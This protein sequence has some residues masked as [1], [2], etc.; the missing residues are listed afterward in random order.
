MPTENALRSETRLAA[1]LAHSPVVLYTLPLSRG[2]SQLTWVSGSC[3]PVLGYTADECLTANWWSE[4][5]HPDDRADVL[6]R[7]PNLLREGR[8]ACRYRFRRRDGSYRWLHD[9]MRLVAESAGPATECI[10][11]WSDVTAAGEAEDLLRQTERQYRGIAEETLQGIA[12]QQGWRVQYVNPAFLRM[13]GY[14][15]PEEVLGRT[16][17]AFVTPEEV[18]ALRARLEAC[19]RGEFVSLH[20]GWQGLRRDGTRLWVESVCSQF[21]WHGRPAVLSFLIDITERKRLEEQFRQ[22]QKMEAIGQLAG[23]VAHDFNNLLTVINGYSELL[24]GNLPGSDPNRRLVDEMK[25]AGERAA[26]LTRQL[27][28][29]SRKQIVVNGVLDLNT[30]VRDLEK[31][32]RRMIGEDIDLA[33]RLHAT[34]PVLADAGRL[35]QILLNLAV[36]ARDAMPQGGKLTIETHDVELDESYT[37][38]RPSVPPGRYVLLAMSDTGCGMSPDVQSHLFEPFFTTKG[39]GKGTGLGLATVYGIVKQSGGHIHFYS[40]PDKG[41]TFKIYLPPAEAETPRRP[42]FPGP[43]AAPRGT[44]TVLVVE[45]E[46][47]VRLLVYHVL[48][49]SGY[50]VLEANAGREALRICVDAEEPI[51]LLITDV[52][53][54]EMGGQ[55]LAKTARGIHRHLRVLYLSGYPDDAVT[56]HGVLHEK[57]HFLQKPFTA[58]VLRFKV[59]EVLDET[60]GEG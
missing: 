54:P 25:R 8:L 35:D 20:P 37:R 56:R 14:A 4:R 5:L 46:D 38:L 52:V 50:R 17:E 57:V 41:A 13:F 6:A 26:S 19:A 53:M 58:S 31:L 45:D 22:A 18:P 12:V 28:V 42:T 40:E 23:G 30:Q 2:R 44:E 39:P 11:S 1:L 36:N 16:W 49:D 21:T 60:S 33:T 47:A 51:H 43:S 59:R 27:L 15:R 55:Q 29:F 7:W 24:L 3:R 32:L 9:E 34:R 10:G 48:E